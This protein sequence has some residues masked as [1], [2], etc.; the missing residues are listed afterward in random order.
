MKKT[1]YYNLEN[2]DTELEIFINNKNE[3]TFYSE[4]Y[5]LDF[6]ISLPKE[7]IE[8]MIIELQ[9]LLKQLK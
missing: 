2:P 9:K 4:G 3:I 7:D 6:S 1:S 8:E 5:G